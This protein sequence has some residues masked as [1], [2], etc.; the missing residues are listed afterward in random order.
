VEHKGRRRLVGRHSPLVDCHAGCPRWARPELAGK[1]AHRPKENDLVTE[2]GHQAVGNG[3]QAAGWWHTDG[4]WHESL[5][6]SVLCLCT[7]RVPDLAP[8]HPRLQVQVQVQ[9]RQ[10]PQEAAAGAETADTSA[11]SQARRRTHES[12][13]EAVKGSTNPRKTTRNM[14][15]ISVKG[16]RRAALGP[17]SCQRWAL[18]EWLLH[19]VSSEWRHV[20]ALYFRSFTRD[21]MTVMVPKAIRA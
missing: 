14:E 8:R 2:N 6:P 12:G 10:R 13:T 15:N 3:A 4:K 7:A 11:K 16:L 18:L 1:T 5:C 19:H 21:C 20:I 9:V 17:C